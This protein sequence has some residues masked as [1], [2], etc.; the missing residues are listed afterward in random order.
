[1]IFDHF[2]VVSADAP[3]TKTMLL[4]FFSPPHLQTVGK[5]LTQTT[6]SGCDKNYPRGDNGIST[7][8]EG[9]ANA[10]TA[11]RSVG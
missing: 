3:F 4:I 9:V 6:V 7:G 8:R 10:E 1:M 2:F 5:I 11:K